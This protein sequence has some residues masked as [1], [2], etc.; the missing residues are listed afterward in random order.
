ME[1]KVFYSFNFKTDLLRW[2]LIHVRRETLLGRVAFTTHSLV[3][4]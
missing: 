2:S 3:G 1:V 4:D